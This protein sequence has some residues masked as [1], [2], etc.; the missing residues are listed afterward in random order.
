MIGTA[1]PEASVEVDREVSL[2]KDDVRAGTEAGDG[3]AI[4]AVAQAGAVKS[5][6]DSQRGGVVTAA[7]GRALLLL[8]RGR[9]ELVELV[10][11]GVKAT[12]LHVHLVADLA[13]TLHQGAAVPGDG[14]RF[15]G[16]GEHP[17]DEL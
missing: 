11:G 2:G 15:S 14:A 13:D 5:A 6:S 9:E 12:G 7:R 17:G 1:V 4:D 3:R 8:V 10:A 16:A